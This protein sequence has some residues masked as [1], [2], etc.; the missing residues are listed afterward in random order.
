M[1]AVNVD[2]ATEGQIEIEMHIRRYV[3]ICKYFLDACDECVR[4]D[5]RDGSEDMFYVVQW[6]FAP[7]T[8][9]D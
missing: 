9:P 1:Y 5:I 2:A 8:I 3:G 6:L 4:C 7:C